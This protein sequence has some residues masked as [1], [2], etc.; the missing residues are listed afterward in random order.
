MV[1]LQAWSFPK[2]FET[3]RIEAPPADI[4]G[5]SKTLVQNK[6][7]PIWGFSIHNIPAVQHFY[8][9]SL[10]P[11]W[12][13]KYSNSKYHWTG[14]LL[15]VWEGG[16]LG[17]HFP[18]DLLEKIWGTEHCVP[19]LTHVPLH[20]WFFINFE[21]FKIHLIFIILMMV[22]TIKIITDFLTA[23]GNIYINGK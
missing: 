9:Y 18:A 14:A 12:R 2:Y 20:L 4:T 19:R 6:R 21:N 23:S 3:S 5:A 1:L 8:Y 13:V 7:R 22:Y 10:R 17:R 16:T 11:V 15:V